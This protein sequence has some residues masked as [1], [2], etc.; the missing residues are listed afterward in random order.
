MENFP[1]R[2]IEVEVDGYTVVISLTEKATVEQ[3]QIKRGGVLIDPVSSSELAA[4]TK[5]LLYTGSLFGGGLSGVR[6]FCN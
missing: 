4:S 5:A 3:T 2:K 6:L 1:F